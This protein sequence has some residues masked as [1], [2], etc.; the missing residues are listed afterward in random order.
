[1]KLDEPPLDS[2]LSEHI[3]VAA[4]HLIL[5]SVLYSTPHTHSTW[6]G[7][8]SLIPR[9]SLRLHTENG[10]DRLNGRLG[11]SFWSLCFLS[12]ISLCR[13]LLQSASLLPLLFFLFIG[14]FYSLLPTEWGLTERG[15]FAPSPSLSLYGCLLLVLS[16]SRFH[17]SDCCSFSFSL[18]FS[19]EERL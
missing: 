16:L 9:R 10:R 19:T 18:S 13:S 17:F 8:S 12:I 3:L 15:Q 6:I 7:K 11:S 1:L 5:V 14:L 2:D 4:R